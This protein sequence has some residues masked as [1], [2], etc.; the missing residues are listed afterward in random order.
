MVPFVRANGKGQDEPRTM[1]LAMEGARHYHDYLWDNFRPFLGLRIIEVGPGFGQYTRRM[2]SGDRHVLAVD[3]DASSVATL[4]A[5]GVG[6]LLETMVLDAEKAVS[7]E[8]KLKAFEADTILMVNVLEHLKDDEKAL[9]FFASLV[10]REG[11]LVV[12][13]P[14]LPC[15]YNRLDREA[16]HHR[17]YVRRTLTAKMKR[18]GWEA[19]AMHYLNFPGAIGWLLAGALARCWQAENSLNSSTTNGLIVC[20]DRFLASLPRLID[21]LTAHLAGLSLLAVGKKP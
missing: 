18:A 20:Y 19:T 4:N 13:V 9:G 2:V 16:G 7:E 17:R 15:L 14:A 8:R 6:P 12:M 5:L 11:R 10:G 3:S 21:P 1:S